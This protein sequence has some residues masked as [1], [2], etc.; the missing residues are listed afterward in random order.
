[1]KILI[2]LLAISNL[3]AQIE[4]KI[5]T[6]SEFKKKLNE[7]MSKKIFQKKDKAFI[8]F[9]SELMQRE[10]DLEMRENKFKEQKAQL[11]IS[12]E[13]FEKRIQDHLGKENELIGCLDS[14]KGQQEQRITRMVE[15]ISG[16]KPDKAAQVLSIQ[17]Q[18]LAIKILGLLDPKLVS[19]VFNL[20]DK[21]ISARL[22]KQFMTMKR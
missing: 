6:E 11:A 8:S 14:V 2:L 9:V 17:D 13:S 5:Y 22:Q 15:I 21:E 1:M 12:M 4:P 10:A 18:E 16:M 20:M 19:K 7:E 3:C